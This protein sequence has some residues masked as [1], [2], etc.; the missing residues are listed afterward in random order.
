M[1][2]TLTT[3]RVTFCI[4]YCL[5]NT[6]DSSIFQFRSSSMKH[7]LAMDL[8]GRLH[9]TTKQKHT[10]SCFESEKIKAVGT[11]FAHTHGTTVSLHEVQRGKRCPE[12]GS[13]G[14]IDHMQ[15]LTK[16]LTTRMVRMY[17]VTPPSS[18]LL[19]PPQVVFALVWFNGAVSGI[20]SFEFFLTGENP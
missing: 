16:T 8:T 15:N 4:F 1:I 19:Y 11:C 10:R 5:P 12:D 14:S 13:T 7:L 6:G 18:D 9:L 2:E 17:S 3:L 20:L